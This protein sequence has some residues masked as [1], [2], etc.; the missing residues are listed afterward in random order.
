MV[1]GNLQL[2]GRAQH[3]LTFDTAQFADFDQE[4]LSVFA[5]WQFSAH[6]GARHTDAHAGV[7]CATHDVQQ[8]ALPH[9]H[10]ANAQAVGV[11]VLN[12]F[13]DLTH[14]DFVERGRHGLELFHFEAGHGQGVSQLL[15]RQGRVAEF[16]QPGFGKLHVACLGLGITGTG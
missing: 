3:A 16:A 1:I 14:N 6:Q 8:T 4:R 10:L 9:I 7:G 11:G 13:F 15:G 5:R 2:L 12:G